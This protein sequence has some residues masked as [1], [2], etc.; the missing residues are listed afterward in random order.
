MGY[1]H[2]IAGAEETPAHPLVRTLHLSDIRTALA[3]GSEDFWAMPSHLLFIG[4]I[5]PVIGVCLAV[6]TSGENALPLLYPLASGFA[7][8]GPVAAIG[9]YEVSRRRELGLDTSWRH[10]FAV[11]RSPAIPSIIALAVLLLV[12]FVAW[13]E[14]ARVIYQWL[15]GP[16]APQSYGHFLNAVFST[17][18]GWRLIVIGNATGFVFAIAVLSVSVVSFPL[19]LERDVGAAVAV[20]T[21]ARVFAAN[22]VVIGLWGLIVALAV[23]IGSAPFFMGLVIVMPVLGHASWHLYRRA[24]APGQV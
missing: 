13:L 8:I 6:L 11:R 16:M 2:V 18:R 21:S 5:Y 1:F 23:A 15:F 14:T 9:L 19:M 12:L 4:L 24:V 3:K 20:V 7:L 17:S 10:A 22:P